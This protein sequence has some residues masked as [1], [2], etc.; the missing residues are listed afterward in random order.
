MCRRGFRPVR[1]DPNQFELA[2]LNLAL[3]ARDAMPDGGSL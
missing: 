2:L 3:N 1:I